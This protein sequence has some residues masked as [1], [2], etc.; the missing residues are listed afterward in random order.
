MNRHCHCTFVAKMTS[1][2][3]KECKDTKNEIT[4]QNRLLNKIKTKIFKNAKSIK[5]MKANK[6]HNAMTLHEKQMCRESLHKKYVKIK[7]GIHRYQKIPENLLL[8]GEKS[9]KYTI[10]NRIPLIAMNDCI[11]ERCLADLHGMKL[12][13]DETRNEQLLAIYNDIRN[14]IITPITFGDKEVRSR[15]SSD[16]SKRL[17]YFK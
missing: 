4:P 11:D 9:R 8:D 14:E 6:G 2:K 13:I 1:A 10:A 15:W 5:K 3:C 17:K 12:N 16:L 7:N